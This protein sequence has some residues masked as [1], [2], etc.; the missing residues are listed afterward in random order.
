MKSYAVYL[1]KK[2]KYFI[3]MLSFMLVLGLVYFTFRMF[4][5]SKEEIPAIYEKISVEMKQQIDKA[6]DEALVAK[7]RAVV[8]AEDARLEIDKIEKI[9]NGEERRKRL[10]EMLNSYG[11]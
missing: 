1:L 9:E 3:V 11:K 8:K 5:S 2:F 6:S 4:S 7:T 10:A